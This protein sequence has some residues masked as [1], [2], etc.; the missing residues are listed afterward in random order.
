MSDTIPENPT[1]DQLRVHYG[2]GRAYVISN[3]P[4]HKT[5]G[6][7]FYK[8]TDIGLLEEG[9][10]RELVRKAIISADETH[11][12]QCLLEWEQEHCYWLRTKQQFEDYALGLHSRRIF[13]DRLW[14]SY[15]PFN[16]KYRPEH[17]EGLPLHWVENECCHVPGQVTEEQLQRG[18]A[19]KTIHCANCGRWSAFTI[20]TNEMEGLHNECDD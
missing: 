17:L 16:Q 8:Q 7:A 19:S 20:I 13:D 9:I 12:Y 3:E 1:L 14:V 4:R 10:W 11:L 6:Y 5:H 15:V 2:V 18:L